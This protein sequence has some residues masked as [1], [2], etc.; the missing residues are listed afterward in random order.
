MEKINEKS[1]FTIR[2][3]VIKLDQEN[4]IY[5]TITNCV[6]L[7]Q[8][9]KKNRKS[10]EENSGPQK[11]LYRQKMLFECQKAEKY[12]GINRSETTPEPSLT[13]SSKAD[14][15]LQKLSSATKQDKEKIKRILVQNNIFTVNIKNQYANM[16]SNTERNIIY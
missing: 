6:Q 5:R 7:S 9:R 1:E 8:N 2:E 14:S 13:P 4:I 12:E 11:R 10:K 16:K 15:F 3:N